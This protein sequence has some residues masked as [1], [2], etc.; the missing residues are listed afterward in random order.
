[1]GSAPFLII[2][3]PFERGSNMRIAAF[4]P[5]AGTACSGIYYNWYISKEVV[6]VLEREFQEIANEWADIRLAKV[7]AE[8]KARGELE[9]EDECDSAEYEGCPCHGPS[10]DGDCDGAGDIMWQDRNFEI[11]VD[12]EENLVRFVCAH[13]LDLEAIM[14]NQVEEIASVEEEDCSDVPF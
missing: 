5:T 13:N 6:E 7:V 9:V 3:V 14:A 12:Y 10:C 2:S 4:G 11:A 8:L 1:M